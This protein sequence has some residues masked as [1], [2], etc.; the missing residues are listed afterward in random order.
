MK[1]YRDV[2]DQGRVRGVVDYVELG[3]FDF[4]DILSRD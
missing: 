1:V 3:V 4:R 2:D